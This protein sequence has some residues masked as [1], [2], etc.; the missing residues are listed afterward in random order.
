MG[1]SSNLPKVIWLEAGGARI[2]AWQS[3]PRTSALNAALDHL[4]MRPEC[5]PPSMGYTVVPLL[6]WLGNLGLESKSIVVS[7]GPC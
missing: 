4:R 2:Q 5:F 7:F 1:R 6:R 3:G